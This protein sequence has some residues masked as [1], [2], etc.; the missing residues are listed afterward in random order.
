MDS[1]YRTANDHRS[2][3]SILEKT[4]KAIITLV[5]GRAY[6]SR[7]A[8]YCFSG[9]KSYAKRHGL[10]LVLYENLFDHSPRAQ[11]R[12][13]AWQKCLAI[14]ADQSRRFEQV[15][16]VDSD[17]LIN[18]RRAPNIFDEVEPSEIGAVKDFS[19]PTPKKY[20]Q[21]LEYLIHFWG[22]LGIS[23]SRS[24]TPQDYMIEWGL[25]P[26]DQVVQTGVIVAN[27]ELHAPLFKMVYETYEDKGAPYW[28]YE[29]RP[30]S[31]E[32]LTKAA[33][34]WLD[35]AFNLVPIF[36]IQ[37]EEMEVFQA[38]PNPLERTLRRFKLPQIHLATAQRKQLTRIHERLFQQSYFLHFAGGQGD[39]SCLRHLS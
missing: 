22:T 37:D 28:H 12:S 24:L 21:R 7:F 9:W 5:S 10:E 4:M 38:P 1:V 23:C 29:M 18:F 31:Y 13:A 16:W 26:T 32:I 8:K 39:M 17:I 34:K 3:F 2:S 25:P 36:G 15:A 30:L 11:A 27:P 6:R 14:G 35:P 19:F 33:V 20:R